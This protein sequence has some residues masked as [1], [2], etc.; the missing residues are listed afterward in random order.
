MKV[1]EATFNNEKK[2]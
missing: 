2:K 1:S